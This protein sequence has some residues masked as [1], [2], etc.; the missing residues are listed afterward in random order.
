MISFRDSC[1][2]HTLHKLTLEVI[3]MAVIRRA[4]GGD[5]FAGRSGCDVLLAVRGEQEQEQGKVSLVQP[6]TSVVRR[7]FSQRL[8]PVGYCSSSGRAELGCATATCKATC[9]DAIL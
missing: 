7:C 8:P 6:S 2:H 5:R 9:E 1:E 3:D 4:V